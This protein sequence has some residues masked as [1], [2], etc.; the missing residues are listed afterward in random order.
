MIQEIRVYKD[1][2][3]TDVHKVCMGILVLLGHG[4]WA[5]AEYELKGWD[6]CRRKI[7]RN[8]IRDMQVTD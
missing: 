7:T 2:P 4:K 5:G 8:L 3:P 1:D 6:D